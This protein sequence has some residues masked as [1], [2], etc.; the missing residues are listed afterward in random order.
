M[1]G[2]K[3]DTLAIRESQADFRDKLKTTATKEDLTAMATKDNIAELKNLIL[4]LLPPKPP[5][6]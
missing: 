5:E 2:V 3:A 6:G 4:Q 1:Q